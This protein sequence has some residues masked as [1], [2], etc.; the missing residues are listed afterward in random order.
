MGC[1]LGLVVGKTVGITGA[2]LLARRLRIGTLPTAST[3]DM[4]SAGAALAGIGFTV[5]LF[6]AELSFTDPA[7]LADAKLAILAA[8]IVAG[9]CGALILTSINRRT[10]GRKGRAR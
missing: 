10:H 8:S 4:S 1:I 2:T 5:A 6:V 9:T 3:L 7:G